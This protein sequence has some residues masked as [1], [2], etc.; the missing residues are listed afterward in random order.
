V[1]PGDEAIVHHVILFTVDP[2][3]TVGVDENGAYTNGD[4]IARLDAND[5]DRMGWA[6]EGAAGDGVLVGGL[7]AG[8]APGSPPT[9]YPQGTGLLLKKSERVIMQ[10]HYNVRER[11]GADQ[12]AVKLEVRDR[13]DRPAIT[14]LADGLVG[15]LFFGTPFVLQP[16]QPSIEFTWTLPIEQM[17][18][19]L[20][21]P[22][23][24]PDPMPSRID[25]YGVFPHMHEA[26]KKM[27]VKVAQPNQDAC[28]TEVPNWDFD[29]QQFYFYDRPIQTVPGQLLSVTCDYD[30]S[31]R[32]SATMPGFGTANEMCTFGMYLVPVP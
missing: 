25:V 21:L 29:W 6:C 20:G 27:H 28:I 32:S 23:Q 13:V 11:D 18:L 16:G 30:T 14:T 12:T 10:V 17:L 19:P 9:K 3:M 22:G 1:L 8:W 5:P 15:T 4:V 24:A 2:A 7:L 31:S 26:G